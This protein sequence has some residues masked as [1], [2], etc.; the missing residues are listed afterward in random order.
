M[1]AL[2]ASTKKV[3]LKRSNFMQATKLIRRLFFDRKIIYHS[4]NFE[5]CHEQFYDHII[6]YITSHNK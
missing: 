4:L 6:T 5:T 2:S 1:R 3:R